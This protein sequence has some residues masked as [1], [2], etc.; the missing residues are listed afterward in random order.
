[1][2]RSIVGEWAK[3]KLDRLGRYLHE[4][5]KIMRKQ[6]RWCEGYYYIDAFAGPGQH[7]VRGKASST[8][9]NMLLNVAS[10][11]QSQKEHRQFLSGSPRVALDIEPPFSGIRGVP[12]TGSVGLFTHGSSTSF[13]SLTLQLLDADGAPRKTAKIQRRP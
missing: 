13:H 3:D 11:G 2:A 7:E 9:R 1:M 4:C 10:F 8:S 12:Q 6:S 5:T